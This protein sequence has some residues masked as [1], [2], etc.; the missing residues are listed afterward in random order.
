[1]GIL[2]PKPPTR[3]E[4][5][6]T[7]ATTTALTGKADV[8]ALGA[9]ANLFAHPA[10]EALKRELDAGRTTAFGVVSDS[11]GDSDGTV[12]TSDRWV[13]KFTRAIAAAYPNFHVMLKKWDGANQRYG[14]WNT[15]QAAPAGR[16]YVSLANRS[17]RWSPADK[18]T[19]RFS[20]KEFDL[21]LLVDVANW[22]SGAEQ[23]LI[24]R[25]TAPGVSWGTAF[26]FRWRLD[27]TG[28]MLLNWSTNGS[29]Y[30]PTRTSTVPVPGVPGTPIWV[31][32]TAT[33]NLSTGYDVKY[34]T[35]TDGVAW[36]QL[37]ASIT[38]SGA[39]AAVMVDTAESMFE[40]GAE[41]WQPTGN[42]MTG[43]VYE[44]Q[45]RDGIDGPLMTSGNLLDWDRYGDPSTTFGGAPTLYV[46]NGAHSG[47][48]LAYFSDPTRLKKMI[49]NYGQSAQFFSTSH[50]EGDIQGQ[51]YW[52]KPYRDWV[53]AALARLPRASAVVVG[54]NPHTSA[55]P[56]EATYGASHVIRLAELSTLAGQQGWGYLDAYKAFQKDPRGVA[57]LLESDGL[58]PNQ[59]GYEVWSD[60]VERMTGL[61]A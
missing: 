15:I 8:S 14:A 31:R 49:Q 28:R 30:E 37:G 21:R 29:S 6:A 4:L 42:I 25:I 56:N 53:T 5:N 58:H 43:K 11:T 40:I 57:A 17:L 3:A 45:I 54:Q 16:R 23:T 22:A 24:T 44:V 38:Y 41:G 32:V 47:Q 50:N 2:D 46:I 20:G 34:Y 33:M 18:E 19:T 9:K 52:V 1:M 39:L 51:K 48:N 7:Y 12:P 60:E 61:L 36:T 13:A 26:Q 35:S 59:A 55:W 10:L 27:G